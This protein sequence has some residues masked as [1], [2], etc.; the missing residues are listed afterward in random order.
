MSNST[1]AARTTSDPPKTDQTPIRCQATGTFPALL[2]QLGVSLLV[3]TIGAGKLVVLGTWNG[4]PVF[5]F[6]DFER[7]F[8]LAVRPNLVAVGTTRQIW[9]LRAAPQLTPYLEPR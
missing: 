4:Q 9:F 7:T 8:G 6:H 1:E 2:Q 3:S 5:S